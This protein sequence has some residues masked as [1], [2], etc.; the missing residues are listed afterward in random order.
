MPNGGT[1]NCMNCSHNRANMLPNDTKLTNRSGRL[2]YCMLRH[3][4]VT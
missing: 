2:P 3:V 1:D 4:P